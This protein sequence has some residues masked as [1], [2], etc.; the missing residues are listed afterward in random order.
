MKKYKVTARGLATFRVEA[1]NETAAIHQAEL[2]FEDV[3][4]CIFD[5]YSWQVEEIVEPTDVI[6]VVEMAALVPKISE[7]FKTI[8]LFLS[9][10]SNYQLPLD[11]ITRVLDYAERSM[12]IKLEDDAREGMEIDMPSYIHYWGTFTDDDTTIETCDGLTVKLPPNWIDK[13][14]AVLAARHYH[15]L[16][17]LLAGDYD[18]ESLDCLVQAAIFEDIPYG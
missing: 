10:P 6:P 1:E 14:L 18:N 12:P 4:I 16:H 15:R 2:R 5:V 11:E 13:G 7:D 8:R 3:D 9:S 17:E